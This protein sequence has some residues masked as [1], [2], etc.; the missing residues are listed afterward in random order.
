MYD[1]DDEPAPARQ[2]LAWA[3]TGSGH[4]FVECLEL[5]RTIGKMDVSRSRPR[6]R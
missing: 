2:R 1:G 3:L 6:P 4:D 5:M